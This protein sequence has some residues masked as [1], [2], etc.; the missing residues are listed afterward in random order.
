MQA[1]ACN[2]CKVE[3]LSELW[4]CSVQGCTAPTIRCRECFP[5]MHVSDENG[6]LK[7]HAHSPFDESSLYRHFLYYVKLYDIILYKFRKDFGG[8]NHNIEYLCWQIFSTSTIVSNFES[9]EALG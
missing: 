2:N 6:K 5:K 8:V 9:P 3:F 4:V 1:S 7:T